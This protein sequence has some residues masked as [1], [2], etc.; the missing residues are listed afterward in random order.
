MRAARS[1][2]DLKKLDEILTACP[3]VS[4]VC[5]DVANGYSE[6]FV[7]VVK[8]VRQKYPRHTII[9]GNVVTNEMTEELILHGADVVKVAAP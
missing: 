2:T 4:T 9:A 1:K 7:D 6:F 3:G 5:L 8:V